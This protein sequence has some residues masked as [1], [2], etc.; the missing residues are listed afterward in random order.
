MFGWLALLARSGRAKIGGDRGQFG[1]VHHEL[2][3]RRLSAAAK[4]ANCTRRGMSGRSSR[5][6][7]WMDMQSGARALSDDLAVGD[8]RLAG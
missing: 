2:T 8:A 6:W 5:G 3:L 1:E 4:P 7:R